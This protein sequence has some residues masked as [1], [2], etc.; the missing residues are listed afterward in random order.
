[1]FKGDLRR[2]AMT[3]ECRNRQC[4]KPITFAYILYIHAKL[5]VVIQIVTKPKETRSQAII[6]GLLQYYV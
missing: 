6:G 5:K 4:L 2:R 3:L 1:V